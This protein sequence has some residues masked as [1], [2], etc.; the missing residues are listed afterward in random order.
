MHD[1][2]YPVICVV[3]TTYNMAETLPRTYKSIQVQSYRRFYWLIIDNGSTDSTKQVVD[4]FISEKKVQ[5]EYIKKEHG[6]R[7]T[8]L[9]TMIDNMGGE[10]CVEIHAD[11][12]LKPDALEIFAREW[13]GLTPSVKNG[14]WAMAAHCED[15]RTHLVVGKPFPRAINRNL[16]RAWNYQFRTV[17]EKHYAM[18]VPVIKTK[19][20]D[21][22]VPGDIQ[23]LNEALLWMEYQRE[24][25]MWFINRKTRIYYDDSPNRYTL[26]SGQTLTDRMRRAAYYSHLKIL[27]TYFRYDKKPFLEYLRHSAIGFYNGMAI[28]MGC[29]DITSELQDPLGKIMVRAM[30]PFL[31]LR[32]KMKEKVITEK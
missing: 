24:Y 19:R 29:G 15:C 23:Y 13:M 27:N 6:I 14:I 1:L 8:A 10:L 22:N 4:R 28:G 2:K 16:R 26:Q 11:D 32:R 17:G 3:T 7:A 30:W 31:K 5:I 25:R 9:N 12:A 18:N 20:I 21:T